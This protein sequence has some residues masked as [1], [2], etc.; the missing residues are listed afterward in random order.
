MDELLI[1]CEECGYKWIGDD[2][3]EDCPS[4]ESE[5]IKVIG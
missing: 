1:N 4:C 2:L 5:N 3:D